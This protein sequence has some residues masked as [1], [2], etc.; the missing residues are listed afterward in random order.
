MTAAERGYVAPMDE[1]D[2]SEL[3]LDELDD[4]EDRRELRRRFEMLL[5]ELRVVVPGV[6]ILL[7]FLFTVPFSTGFD[8]LDE[9]GRIFYG[10]TLLTASLSVVALLT[11]TFLHRMG[12][13]RGRAV[14]LRWS[15][16][17]MVAGLVL[18]TVALISGLWGITRFVFS[19]TTT[20][21]L[22]VPAAIAA[23]AAWIALPL[24]LR[25]RRSR[26]G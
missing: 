19:P 25:E 24:Y 15:I 22:M 11:P 21:L 20:W 18:F 2:A 10:T 3:S 9:T 1:R 16:R 12:D 4:I 14:R 8:E 6:Q 13:R 23:G 26:Q 7:A 5:Q 17:M